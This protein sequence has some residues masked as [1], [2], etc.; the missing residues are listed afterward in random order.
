MSS[1]KGDLPFSI[2]VL[3][4]SAVRNCD[5]FH[6]LDKDVYNILNWND[7]KEA[8]VEIP[9]KPARVILQD[10]TY[11]ITLNELQFCICAQQKNVFGT[12][13][14]VCLHALLSIVLVSTCVK[15]TQI[16][17][18]NSKSQDNSSPFS[19]STIASRII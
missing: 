6:V 9:F 4:E 8:M 7:T 16:V 11:A 2:R 13:V 5:Q 3:L 12:S 14:R 19:S 17:G 18:M 1:W 15:N 10:F